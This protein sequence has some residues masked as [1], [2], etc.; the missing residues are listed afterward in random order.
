MTVVSFG[1]VKGAPGVTTLTCLVGATWPDERQVM[2]VE[3]DPGG[4]DLAARFHLSSRLGWPSFDAAAR[5]DPSSAAAASHLQQLPGGLDVLVGTRGAEVL[6]TSNSLPALLASAKSAPEGSWDVLLDLGRVGA[7][8][9]K[10]TVCLEHSDSVVI[11]HCSDVASVMQVYERTTTVLG[12][13]RDRI[14]LVV[15][16][17]GCY[18]SA[19]IEKFTG[20]PV[21]GEIPFDPSAASVATGEK[22]GERRL[23]RS[24]LVMSAHRLAVALGGGAHGSDDGVPSGEVVHAAAAVV[25]GP[26]RAGDREPADATR[27]SPERGRV[28]RLMTRAVAPYASGEP[29]ANGRHGGSPE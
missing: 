21:V 27:R 3:C 20:L 24:Q 13:H 12:E 15:I 11:V 8:E 1:S 23:R 18:S 4:G 17:N 6:T 2:V 22:P 28:K 7:D 5:R 14:G 19:E 26:D 10:S 29:V 16:R 25:E 9:K